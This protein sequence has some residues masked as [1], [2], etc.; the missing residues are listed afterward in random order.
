[1]KVHIKPGKRTK[2]FKF[3]IWDFQVSQDS[4]LGTLRL[5]FFEDPEDENIVYLYKAY[6]D[7]AAIDEHR[8]LPPYE[9]HDAI[10]TE[11]LESVDRVL[12]W[13]EATWSLDS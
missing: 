8:A 7:E 9:Q 10:M 2:L 11:C 3:L 13:S 5:D 12:D 6:R 4:E 1:M